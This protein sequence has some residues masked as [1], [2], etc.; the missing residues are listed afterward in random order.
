M[1]GAEMATL[2]PCVIHSGV[3][4][5]LR[6]LDM[7]QCRSLHGSDI[8]ILA[9]GVRMLKLQ[10][11]SSSRFCSGVRALRHRTLRY[12]DTTHRDMDSIQ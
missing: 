11:D 2:S 5:Y 4:R 9:W 10:G 12:E 1:V 3:S 7:C 6:L 8:S